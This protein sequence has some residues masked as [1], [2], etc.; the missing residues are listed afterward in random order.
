ME[1]AD[2]RQYQPRWAYSLGLLT[3]L[4]YNQLEK[5]FRVRR[6]DPPLTESP[7]GAHRLPGSAFLNF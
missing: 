7:L 5:E 1:S 4:D 2:E 3:D 6:A